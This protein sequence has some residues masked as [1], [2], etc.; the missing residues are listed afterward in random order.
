MNRKSAVPEYIWYISLII[1]AITLVV[2]IVNIT[3]KSNKNINPPENLQTN[4]DVKITPQHQLVISSLSFIGD[5]DPQ[6]DGAFL[7]LCCNQK[8]QP[9]SK[10]FNP[11]NFW[12]VRTA[13]GSI[14]LK[15]PVVIVN[16][17]NL[18]SMY[19]ASC[20]QKG[21]IW[22]LYYGEPNQGGVLLKKDSVDAFTPIGQMYYS[23]NVSS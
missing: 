9:L 5:F 3:K 6:K 1:I 10:I 8:C 22:E 14:S 19:P 4:F 21:A 16:T 17:Q 12:F 13:T 18:T 7:Y 20:L 2:G 11:N 15:T 23:Y